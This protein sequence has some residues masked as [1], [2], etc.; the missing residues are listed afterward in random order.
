MEDR[1]Y[2]LVFRYC[3]TLILMAMVHLKHRKKSRIVEEISVTGIKFAVRVF[4][5]LT[6]T[7]QPV[8]RVLITEKSIGF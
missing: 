3:G 1:R 7:L 4:I 8:V 2:I 5:K 6:V